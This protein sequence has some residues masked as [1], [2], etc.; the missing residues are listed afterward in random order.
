MIVLFL[1]ICLVGYGLKIPSLIF[2]LTKDMT[3]I[4]TETLHVVFVE[5][6]SPAE[7][8][9]IQVNDE[10]VSIN[11][12]PVMEDFYFR[13][14]E[15]GLSETNLIVRRN[16][17]NKSITFSEDMYTHSLGGQL[18]IQV[19]NFRQEPFSISKILREH[20]T[21]LFDYGDDGSIW[22][23]NRRRDAQMRGLSLAISFFSAAVLVFKITNRKDLQ[24]RK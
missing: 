13:T 14:D 23:S 2:K 4:E 18:G 1:L 11:G 21:H 17:E 5:S 24:V 12:N 19:S 3:L 15:K 8:S 10:L 9:G 20:I 6:G 16:N 22:M 7:K